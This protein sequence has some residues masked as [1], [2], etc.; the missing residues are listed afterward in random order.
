MFS[1]ST[2]RSGIRRGSVTVSANRAGVAADNRR[3]IRERQ[4]SDSKTGRHI[5]T[6]GAVAFAATFALD[7]KGDLLPSHAESCASSPPVEQRTVPSDVAPHL[8]IRSSKLVAVPDPVGDATR[9]QRSQVHAK[10]P[11]DAAAKRAMEVLRHRDDQCF[12]PVPASLLAPRR[13][14][15]PNR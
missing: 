11:K 8:A 12:S 14:R 15:S 3:F 6:L 1:P 2:P 5:D 4:A 13:R 10:K 7:S 9:L